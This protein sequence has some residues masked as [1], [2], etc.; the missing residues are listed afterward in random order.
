MMQ[1]PNV[2]GHRWLETDGAPFLLIPVE[3][4]PSWT[5][6]EGDY[7]LVIDVTDSESADCYVLPE[8]SVAVLGDEALRT[9]TMESRSLVVQWVYSDSENDIREGV[10]ELDL[11]SISWHNGPELECDGSVAVIDAATPGREAVEDMMF[12]LELPAGKFRVDSATVPLA[13]HCA[14][15][16]YRLVSLTGS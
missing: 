12:V 15:K 8:R 13:P 3:L 1:R 6:Y 14:A 10:S 7:D 5:G 4:L 9:T 16:L 11:C 2:E